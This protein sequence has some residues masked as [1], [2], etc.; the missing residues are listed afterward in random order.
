MRRD[1]SF[2]QRFKLIRLSLE[3]FDLKHYLSFIFLPSLKFGL[4][5]P[6]FL[7]TCKLDIIQIISYYL[8]EVGS[9][10]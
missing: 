4:V 2:I 10:V 5:R 8:E 7:R 3:V 9:R 1:K 6:W